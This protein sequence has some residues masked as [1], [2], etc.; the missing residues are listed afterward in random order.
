MSSHHQPPQPRKQENLLLNLAFNIV[1]PAVILSKLSPEERLGPLYALVL[2]IAFPFGYGVFDLITRRKWNLFSVVG[3]ISVSLTGG[4]GLLK[5]DGFWF[6]VKEAAVPATFAVAVLATLKTKK[7]LVRALIL[8][9]SVIDVAKVESALADRGNRPQ[10]DILLLNATWWLS[11]SFALSAVLNFA[12]ARLVLTSP[13]G[14]P[15]FTAQLGRMT[16]MSWPV[17]VVPSMVIMVFI[18][19]RLFGGIRQLTGL[20]I[21]DIVHKKPEKK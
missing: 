7:P 14:T 17:I 18:L 21:E 15:E 9:E 20:E 11:G 19:W 5:V 13:G 3:V 6:A 1:V 16:W 4:L 8:N 12:L 10:F 2:G